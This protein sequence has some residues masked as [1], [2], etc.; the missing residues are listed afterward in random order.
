MDALQRGIVILLR[1]AVTGEKLELPAEFQLEDACRILSKHQV[2]PLAYQGA[3]NC[4]A[5]QQEPVMQQLLNAYYRNMIRSEKQM[6][7]AERIYRAFE[8]NRIDYMPLKGCNM[9]RLYPKPELRVMGDADILIRLDQAGRIRQVMEEL[10]FCLKSENDHVFNWLSD[11]LYVELHKSVVPPEDGDYYAYYGTGWRLGVKGAGHRYDM[12]PEDAFV[13]LFTHFARHY[14]IA[15]IGCRHV[16][17][18]YVYCRTY[19]QMDE[20]YIRA[21]L[22]KLHLL[23]FYENMLRVLE[24]WFTGG[25]T[26]DITELI[27][28][29]VFSGGSWGT[30]EAMMY[31]QE[32]KSARKHGG[33]RHANLRSVIRAIFPPLGSIKLR[34][35][36]LCRASWLLPAMWVVRWFDI[37]FFSP[38]NIRRKVKIL[39][40]I[41]DDVILSHQQALNYVG[42][43]YY[44]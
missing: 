14:R 17:D 23:A 5:D 34:Y 13:F 7:A 10:G 24:V 6:R 1:S 27:T 40:S 21:E 19:L 28:A 36:V 4:G 32:V 8:E 38:Q 43:D 37:L 31:S 44:F 39:R 12:S 16:T 9:K 25:K 42:L 29:F 41:D 33:I 35:T 20:A 18:L 2:L 30:T 11:D 26:D 15:G 22:E 3:V